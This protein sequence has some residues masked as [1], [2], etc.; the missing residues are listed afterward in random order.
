MFEKYTDEST[1][2]AGGGGEYTVVEGF[3]WTNGVLIWA[4]DV[5]GQGLTTPECGNITAAQT[6]GQAR[7]RDRAAVELEERDARWVKRFN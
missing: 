2:A 7:K 6:H 4:A 3:G 1:N 5:F